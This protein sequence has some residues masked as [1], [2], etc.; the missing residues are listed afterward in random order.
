[1]SQQNHNI[2]KKH[3]TIAAEWLARRD[4]GL[5][6]SE[7]DAY[8][9]WLAADPEDGRA[10]KRIEKVWQICDRLEEWRPA[11]SSQPNP[12]LL[13]PT[14]ARPRFLLVLSS[15][16]AIAAVLFLSFYLPARISNPEKA[17][18]VSKT[19]ISGP[20]EQAWVISGVS[21]QQKMEDGSIIDVR[22]DTILEVNFNTVR[23][24]VHLVRG[25]AFFIVAHDASRPF[26]VETAG[27]TV[28]ALGT[29]FSV[30][31]DQFDVSVEVTE[32]SV[33]VRESKALPDLDIK[34]AVVLNAGEKTVLRYA[35]LIPFDEMPAYRDKNDLTE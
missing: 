6:G 3:E 16:L 33:E 2:T 7:Q 28:Q 14:P 15:A 25:E 35:R 1:M 32:G 10:V 13:A 31:L 30:A 22:S 29:A 34:D 27:V 23:R 18:P 24:H 11:H 8:V 19:T 26:I 5:S 9:E 4:R 17:Q 20:Q 21:G 12:D